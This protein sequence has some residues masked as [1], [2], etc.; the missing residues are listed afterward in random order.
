M[1]SE[2]C[3]GLFH[4]KSCGALGSVD[5]LA[6]EFFNPLGDRAFLWFRKPGLL[7][8]HLGMGARLPTAYVVKISYCQANGR[9]L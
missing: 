9:T 2:K 8:D 6:S 5:L 1:A 4:I 3:W 7:H